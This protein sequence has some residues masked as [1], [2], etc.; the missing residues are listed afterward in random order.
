MTARIDDKLS[1]P[2]EA[3]LKKPAPR[4]DET[5]SLINQMKSIYV[6]ELDATIYGATVEAAQAEADRVLQL[7]I[8]RDGMLL[9]QMQVRS[10]EKAKKSCIAINKRKAKQAPLK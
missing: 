10:M 2:R 3:L 9:T 7:S 1:V 4:V 5:G 6:P 8:K